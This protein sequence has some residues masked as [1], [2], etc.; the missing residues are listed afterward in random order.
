MD[1]AIYEEEDM[2]RPDSNVENVPSIKYEES[3]DDVSIFPCP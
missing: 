2:T 1:V 3:W